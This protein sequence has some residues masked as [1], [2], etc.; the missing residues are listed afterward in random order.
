[1]NRIALPFAGVFALVA[2][3]CAAHCEVPREPAPSVGE[4]SRLSTSELFVLAYEHA[5]QEDYETER[6]VLAIAAARSASR[7]TARAMILLAESYS[8]AGEAAR[9]ASLLDGVREQYHD[10]DTRV[11]P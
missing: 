10:P 9:C 1:M 11:T 8:M 2:S 6:E 4:L 5:W 7:D 3:V